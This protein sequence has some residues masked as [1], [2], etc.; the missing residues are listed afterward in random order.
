MRREQRHLI[1]K[2]ILAPAR[3]RAMHAKLNAQP[4]G[5]DP[6]L[7]VY[8]FT[9]LF[10]NRIETD[11]LDAEDAPMKIRLPPASWAAVIPFAIL[12]GTTAEVGGAGASVQSTPIAQSGPVAATRNT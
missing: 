9:D 6:R 3:M 11:S 12:I 1:D 4:Q 2:L 8:F 5:F 10:L 7:G